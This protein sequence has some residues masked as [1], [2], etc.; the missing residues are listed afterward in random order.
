[1]VLYTIADIIRAHALT[2]EQLNQTFFDYVLLGKGTV[3]AA[4]K[5]THVPVAVLEELRKAYTYWMP[6]DHRHTFV[7][8]LSNHLSFMLFA[9]AGIFPPH[10]WPKKISFHGLIISGG[11]KMSKS[12]GNVITIL[13]IKEHYGA[14]VFRFYMTS[15]TSLE[16]TF[17]WRESEAE[18]ARKTIE[19]LFNEM[20]EAVTF[21]K[22]GSVRPLFVSKFHS[23]LKSARERIE[24]MKLR[25]YNSAV[26]F[27][28]LRIVKDA[29]LTLGKEELYAFYDLIIED[30]I[31][32]VSPVCPHL[33]E[34]LWARA[35][36]E[37]FVSVAPWPAHDEER[38]D[39]KLEAF[40]QAVEKT[41]SDVLNVLRIVREKSKK[42]PKQVY[43]YIMPFEVAYFDAGALGK[44]VGIPVSIF[45]VNDP[46]KIDPENKSGKAK[47]GKPGIYVA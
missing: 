42:E 23:L 19:R 18:N 22:K 45:A 8:H 34:E 35:R 31:K 1:M 28:M 41:V 11:A 9:F 26:V 2:R 17:D 12:K 33:A 38:I 16:G 6:M 32:L 7:L 25:E 30:W 15:A 3:T 24:S 5:S 36:K 40:E 4:A 21:R 39:L 37:G 13:H 43:L 29:K 47:P 44:R 10:D 46:K 20:Q 27:E 14:D